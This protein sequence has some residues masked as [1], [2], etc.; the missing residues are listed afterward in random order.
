M[1]LLLSNT[2]HTVGGNLC[3][4][5]LAGQKALPGV[6]STVTEWAEGAKTGHND[7]SCP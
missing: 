2:G 3:D 4:S 5:R 6:Q 1:G 7:T